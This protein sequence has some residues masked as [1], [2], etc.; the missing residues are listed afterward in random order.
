[1]RHQPDSDELDRILRYVVALTTL[2]CRQDGIALP[3]WW[4]THDPDK[5]LPTPG[6]HLNFGMAHG[7]AGLLAFLA[8]AT[9]AGH[10]VEGQHDAITV[11]TGWFDQRR[12][13]GPD[14][15]WWPPWLTR[16]ELRAGRPTQTRPGQVSWCYGT[17]G[18][19]RALQ[20]AA[21]ATGDARRHDAAEDALA[22]SLTETQLDRITEPGRCHGIAGVYQTIFRAA[23]EARTP[24]PDPAHWC[25]SPRTL[26]RRAEPRPEFAH[27]F[28]RSEC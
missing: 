17:V 22:A 15:P 8:V 20:L 25:C 23:R 9:L 13:D 18:I 14:G 3:G 21:H 19:G 7:A 1:M 12:Q 16:A 28:R 26:Q 10:V 24:S 27:H 11:L 2:Q 4:V 5:I 6:G